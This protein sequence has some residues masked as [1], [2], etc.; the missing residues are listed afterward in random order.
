M[1][2]KKILAAV[3]AAAMVG[4]VMPTAAFAETENDSTVELI[5]SDNETKE[6]FHFVAALTDDSSAVEITGYAGSADTAVIPDSVEGLPVTKIGNLDN[7]GS[8][9]KLVIPA[10]VTS[11]ENGAF[12]KLTELEEIEVAEDNQYYSSFGG[13]LYNKDMTTL[14]YYPSSRQESSFAFP[15]IVTEISEN[16]I[17]G[18]SELEYLTLG[19]GLTTI[20]AE[21]FSNCPKLK[22]ITVS[23]SIEDI[24]IAYVNANSAIEAYDVYEFNNVYS[25]V[26]GVLFN[27]DGS[28]L[29]S[30][31]AGKTDEAYTVPDSV[32][33]ICDNSF[34]DCEALKKVTVGELFTAFEGNPFSGTTKIESF[35]V[36]G[37][38]GSVVAEDGILYSTDRLT[39]VKYPSGKETGVFTVPDTITGFS[40]SAFIDCPNISAFAVSDKNENFSVVDGILFSKDGT[41]LVKYPAGSE[42][43]YYE[44]A[45][46]VTSVADDAFQNVATLSGLCFNGSETEISENALYGMRSDLVLYGYLDSPVQSYASGKYEFI[47][48][49]GNYTLGDVNGDGAVN[50]IDASEVLTVYAAVATGNRNKFIEAQ[51]VAADVNADGN[52]DA[53]DASQILSYYAYTATTTDE[54]VLSIADYLDSLKIE[55]TTDGSEES[56]TDAEETTEETTEESTDESEDAAAAAEDTTEEV[57]E[58]ASDASESST[59]A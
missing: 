1:D 38:N 50:A 26:D 58:A 5:T 43:D 12:S 45:D 40:T 21:T 7:N 14:V 10:S 33:T 2:T 30:Y 29:I 53:L 48:L 44:V 35:A 27:K 36:N 28:S 8:I 42:L 57:S 24:D 3:A 37:D 32:T 20:G 9:T 25:S 19:D 22:Y 31:P 51:K 6:E 47:A 55:E 17:S 18:V 39:L 59:E 11:I 15:N 56:D 41:T 16:A 13:V 23:A 52:I 4:S 54:E 49:D 46:T 34:A